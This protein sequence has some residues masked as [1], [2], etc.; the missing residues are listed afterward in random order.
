MLPEIPENASSVQI[1]AE[2]HNLGHKFSSWD[3]NCSDG[4]TVELE[5]PLLGFYKITAFV[6]DENDT[7]IEQQNII[8]QIFVCILPS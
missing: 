1:E 7:L 2:Q 5:L 4:V 6:Y 3:S 8:A